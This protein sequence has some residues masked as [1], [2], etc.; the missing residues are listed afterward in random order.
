MSH[1]AGASLWNWFKAQAM[2]PIILVSAYA[3][4]RLSLSGSSGSQT[5][6]DYFKQ[7][8]LGQNISITQRLIGAWEGLRVGWILVAIALFGVRAVQTAG[9]RFQAQILALG[10]VVTGLIGLFTALDM[11]RSMGL[12][13]PVIP[14]G[15]IFALRTAWWHKYRLAPLLAAAALVLPASQAVGRGS[16]PVA[17]QRSK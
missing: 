13:V 8:V 14:L 12:I 4:V 7:F 3:V 11:S 10:V 16:V 5:V 2:L 17:S 9:I 6:S 15:W 1:Q